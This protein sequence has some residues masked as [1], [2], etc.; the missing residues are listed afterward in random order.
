MSGRRC[1]S[2]LTPGHFL[3]PQRPAA[4]LKRA[5]AAL[6]ASNQSALAEAL[7]VSRLSANELLNGRR[8][9]SA[10]M[11]LR[12]ARVFDTSPEYWMDLQRDWDL[13]VARREH[14]AEIDLLPPIR[15]AQSPS[16]MERPIGEIADEARRRGGLRQVRS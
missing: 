10:V 13:H 5:F 4:V 1:A 12:L 8:G 16:D 9:I 2:P 6:G 14:G 15:T 3:T 7:G 11:A